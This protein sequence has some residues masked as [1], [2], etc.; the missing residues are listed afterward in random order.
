MKK[1]KSFLYAER[2]MVSTEVRKE[3]DLKAYEHF[4]GC[5]K[6]LDIG[7]GRGRFI[8]RN[9]KMIVGIDCN[10]N[11]IMK[12]NLLGYNVEKGEATK[13]PFMDRCFDGVHSSYV[14]E[15]MFPADAWKMLSEMDRILKIGGTFVIRSPILYD[16][17]YDTFSH[18]RPYTPASIR[19]YMLPNKNQ[20]T[21]PDLPSLYEEIDFQWRRDKRTFM[22][23]FKKTCLK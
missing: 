12:C 23:V 3:M 11:A 21:F 9:P 14:I 13:I 2:N 7:C 19:L 4:K 6:V 8:S 20:T 17:F 15:H 22:L 1:E 16:G 18:I 5:E 10:A